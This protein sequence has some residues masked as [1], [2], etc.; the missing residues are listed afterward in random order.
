MAE[1]MSLRVKHEDGTSHQLDEWLVIH[2]LRNPSGWTED[3][4]RECRLFAANM[5]EADWMVRHPQP[6]QRAVFRAWNP[7]LEP[8]NNG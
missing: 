2:V 4:V 7:P 8:K 5:M 3:A 6:V 1:L